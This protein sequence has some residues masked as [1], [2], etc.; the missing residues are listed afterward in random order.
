[1]DSLEQNIRLLVQ[2][3]LSK[4]DVPEAK[5]STQTTSPA[6]AAPPEALGPGLF[7]DIET[8]IA[9][10]RI[11]QKELAKLTL[12][13]RRK[14]IA[15]MRQATLDNND[16]LSNLAVED[17]GFG[18]VEDKLLKHA[19]VAEKTPG[20]EDLV[21][22]AFSDDDGMSLVEWAPW[23]VIGAIIPSTNPSSTVVCN[24]IGMI[25]AG[26]SVVFGPHP[27]A[28]KIS[29]M[30]I[31][32]MNQ[33]IVSAGGPM[34]LLTAM[35][36]PTIAAA[37]VLLSHEDIGMLVVTG[38]PG[39]VKLAMKS[40]KKAIA[41]GP[42]NPPCVVDETADIE[43]AGKDIVAG[44]S[45]DNNIICIC[46]K[47]VIVVDSVADRLKQAMCNNGAYL[48]DEAQTRAITE[49]VIAEPGGPGKEG[50]PNKDF[51]G[52]NASV[53]AKAIGLDI[54]DSVRLLLCEV[55]REHPLIWTEQLMPV[56]PLTRVKNVDDAIDLAFECEHGFR[57][58]A[59]MHSL[60][61]AKLSKMARVMNC[62][63]FIKN[64]P[65]YAGLGFG[66]AGFTSLSIASPT[67]DGLTRAR[68]F[69]RERRCTVVDYFRI[70]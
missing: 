69:T 30:A 42:G 39:I 48:L 20:V 50:M 58:T 4:M 54:P 32:L 18:R 12:V 25:A 56:M 55:G 9:A 59:I 17:T 64:G 23:G 35:A 16:L 67:G 40:G 60:N 68:T 5:S 52:K 7:A 13:T 1:M 34:N 36:N 63:I 3:V 45:F 10:A 61:I 28:K 15:A 62:S 37:N 31:S 70:V 8:A 53:I 26:N 6:P 19:L 22:N 43:K 46:E 49:L 66:G 27:F 29:G 14:I 41:A 65:S 57:H 44:G 51:V 38:G 21:P 47:E 24:G 2:D 11:A 33:A